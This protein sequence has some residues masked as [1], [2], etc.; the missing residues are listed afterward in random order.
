MVRAAAAPGREPSRMRLAATFTVSIGLPPPKLTMQ[1]A[2]VRLYSSTSAVTVCEG[3]CWLAPLNTPARGGAGCPGNLVEQLRAPQRFAGHDQRALEP[4]ALE[5]MAEA[6][7]LA[8]PE[9]HF[10][11]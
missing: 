1:S 9:G 10:F 2:P 11:Q 8:R 3:T 5:L 4:P 6:R 7:S